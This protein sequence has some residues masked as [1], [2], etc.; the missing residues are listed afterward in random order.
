MDVYLDIKII[1]FR[2]SGSKGSV[3]NEDLDKVSLITTLR[4]VVT[5]VKLIPVSF[6]ET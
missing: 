1:R 2:I 6:P 5:S 3:I 4:K